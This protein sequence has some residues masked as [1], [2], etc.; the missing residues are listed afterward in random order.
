MAI[1]VLEASESKEES[2]D[3]LLVLGQVTV[4]QSY[5]DGS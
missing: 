3:F 1:E 2:V 4:S 5:G